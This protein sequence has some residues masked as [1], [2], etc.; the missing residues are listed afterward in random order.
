MFRQFSDSSTTSGFRDLMPILQGKQRKEK[1]NNS[2]T[3]PLSAQPETQQADWQNQ[4]REPPW[5]QVVQTVQAGELSKP[6][7][8]CNQACQQYYDAKSAEEDA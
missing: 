6:V 7:Y 5:R 8:T 3:S 2:G 4:N 1:Q